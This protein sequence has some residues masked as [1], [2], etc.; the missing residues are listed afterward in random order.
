MYI[1]SNKHAA[2]PLS[3]ASVPLMSLN[4]TSESQDESELTLIRTV[5][6]P[7]PQR[8]GKGWGEEAEIAP[9]GGSR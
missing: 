1:Q 2:G 7:L 6:P 5:E 3:A 8:R 9:H 4:T